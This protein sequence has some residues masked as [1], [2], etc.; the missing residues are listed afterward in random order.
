MS[1]TAAPFARFGTGT[2]LAR[3]RDWDEILLETV[4]SL[5]LVDL[6]AATA[7]AASAEGARLLDLAAGDPAGSETVSVATRVVS[8]TQGSV[9]AVSTDKLNYL[10]CLMGE[11][12]KRV[13]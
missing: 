4:V 8:A 12:S 1:G 6:D 13:L 10:N 2:E 5:P 3:L 7:G 9:Q 11:Q